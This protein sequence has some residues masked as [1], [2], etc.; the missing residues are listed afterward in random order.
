MPLPNRAGRRLFSVALVLVLLTAA[1]LPVLGA[2]PRLENERVLSFASRIIAHKDG[3]LQVAETI[4]VNG[5]GIAIENGIC[6]EFSQRGQQ[7]APKLT[8]REVKMDDQPTVFRVEDSGLA[9]RICVGDPDQPLITGLHTYKILY[10]TAPLVTEASGRDRLLWD[11]TGSNWTIPVDSVTVAIELPQGVPQEELS[12][13]GSVEG[14]TGNEGS[15]AKRYSFDFDTPGTVAFTAQSLAPGEKFTVKLD[16]PLGYVRHRTWGI[17]LV[18]IEHSGAFVALIGLVVLLLYWAVL[19]FYWGRPPALGRLPA[20]T[21]PPNSVSAAGLRYLRQRATDGKMF[22]LVLVSLARTGIM[23]IEETG[24]GYTLRRTNADF[25]SLAPEERD[26]AKLLF[27]GQESVALNV[28]PA[29]VKNASRVLRKALK[30]SYARSFTPVRAFAWPALIVS[31]LAIIASLILEVRPDL[32]SEFL[33]AFLLLMVFMVGV[34]LL[35]QIW[36]AS[37]NDWK[38]DPQEAQVPGGTEPN[39]PQMVT[40]ILVSIMLIGVVVLLATKVSSVWALLLAA[41][42]AV[43]VCFMK[44]MQVPTPRGQRLLDELEA[45]RLYLRKLCAESTIAF[46]DPEQRQ[47]TFEEFA[48][49]ALAF[50]L[51]GDWFLRIEQPSDQAEFRPAWYEGEHFKQFYTRKVPLTTSIL[52]GL[53]GIESIA[54]GQFGR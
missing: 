11:V 7:A 23:T 37:L 38:S 46:E 27:G 26:F 21:T 47:S 16:W 28:H 9:R 31:G 51:E 5:L 22:T 43:N 50:D 14:M 45:F 17:P 25:H 49:H 24:G 29:R 39:R 30:K 36:P 12:V 8:V 53:D 20:R 52:P 3:S 33:P 13:E 44:I 48:D 40:A 1:S 6:R 34:T 19:W 42:T 41:Q 35:R 2:P 54:G 10:D 18:M 15:R 32:K 4:E